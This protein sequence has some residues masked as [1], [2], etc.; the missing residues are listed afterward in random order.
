M[1]ENL[2]EKYVEEIVNII[3]ENYKEFP[4]VRCMI[5]MFCDDVSGG[6]ITVVYGNTMPRGVTDDSQY[7]VDQLISDNLGYGKLGKHT[8]FRRDNLSLEAFEWKTSYGQR[9]ITFL[10]HDLREANIRF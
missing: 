1:T 5:R 3:E 8:R 2:H 10:T 7:R 9:L 6:T 4:Q